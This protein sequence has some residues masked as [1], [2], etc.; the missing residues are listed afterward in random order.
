MSVIQ[1]EICRRKIRNV[2]TVSKNLL[3]SITD[4]K[5]LCTKTTEIRN[6]SKGYAV[7]CY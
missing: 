7:L 5:L 4:S 6:T 3:F 1:L 2:F